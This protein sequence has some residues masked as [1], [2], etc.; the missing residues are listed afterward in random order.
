MDRFLD[1]VLALV[2]LAVVVALAIPIFALT[3]EMFYALPIAASVA[4]TAAVLF[5]AG[6]AF[7]FFARRK[8][9]RTSISAAAGSA[10]PTAGE[11]LQSN[12]GTLTG[13]Q[14]WHSPEG[15]ARSRTCQVALVPAANA[16]HAAAE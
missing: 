14:S 13:T 16:Q 2:T 8:A 5:F 10:S 12:G 4:I 15:E 7:R 6:F 9:K 3:I 11:L 1:V